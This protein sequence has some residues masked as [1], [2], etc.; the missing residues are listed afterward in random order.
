M[1]N[2]IFFLFRFNFE[3]YF[4]DNREMV[5]L[6]ILMREAATTIF[7]QNKDRLRRPQIEALPDVFAWTHRYNVDE[8][9]LCN[10]KSFLCRP[11]VFSESV[12]NII[13]GI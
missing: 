9:N 12:H 11:L 6:S 13:K 3:E 5:S 7:Y 10:F 8:K 2:L 1:Y 4:F